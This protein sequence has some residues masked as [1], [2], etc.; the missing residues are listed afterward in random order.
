V[1][2]SYHHR[3]DK[4]GLWLVKSPPAKVYFWGPTLIIVLLQQLFLCCCY[5]SCSCYNSQ[6]FTF[7]QIIQLYCTL[8]V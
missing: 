8:R 5:C 3:A 6:R 2:I 4:E 1:H 7:Q